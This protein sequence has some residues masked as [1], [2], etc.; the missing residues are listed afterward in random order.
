MYKY[1]KGNLIVEDETW[2]SGAS[3][4]GNFGKSKSLNY[5]IWATRYKN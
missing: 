3:G 2:F 1:M 4:N 5:P